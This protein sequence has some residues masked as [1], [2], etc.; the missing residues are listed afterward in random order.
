[1]SETQDQGLVYRRGFIPLGKRLQN[2]KFFR[3]NWGIRDS[4]SSE[5]IG[6][7][8]NAEEAEGFKGT[9]KRGWEISSAGR[10]ISASM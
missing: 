7:S 4:E 1:L 2:F 6:L 9:A 3:R 10:V 8:H 5:M